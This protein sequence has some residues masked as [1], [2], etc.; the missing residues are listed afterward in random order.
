MTMHRIDN[1]EGLSEVLGQGPVMETPV[2]AY[3]SEPL[4]TATPQPGY[5]FGKPMFRDEVS[6]ATHEPLVV[7]TVGGNEIVVGPDQKFYVRVAATIKDD[8][9]AQSSVY[10]EPHRLP[11]PIS[12]P[13]FSE[14]GVIDARLVMHR[15]GRVDVQHSMTGHRDDVRWALPHVH[16]M[17]EG[18]LSGQAQAKQP[19]QELPAA[20]GPFVVPIPGS[21]QTQNGSRPISEV[22]DSP[23]D[24]MMAE[25]GESTKSADKTL[26]HN[27]LTERRLK[28]LKLL[29][30]TA[31][32]MYAWQKIYGYT[33]HGENFF[34]FDVHYPTSLLK[35]PVGDAQSFF[36][37]SPFGFIF[38]LF[39]R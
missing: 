17:F 4:P 19:V 31:L 10:V 30:G 5:E 26:A 7:G 25:P 23:L 35:S 36:E 28:A 2:A 37:H 15:D 6:E 16:Q 12:Q 18:M 9:P 32:T 24:D 3:E 20:S 14:T 39:H 8:T 34:Q 11:E 29:A 22:Y 1:L 33:S 27:I 13:D 38:N 21:E